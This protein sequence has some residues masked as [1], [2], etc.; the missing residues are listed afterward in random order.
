MMES[1]DPEEIRIGMTRLGTR[2]RSISWLDRL[3]QLTKKEGRSV[4][5][6]IDCRHSENWLHECTLEMVQTIHADPMPI[7]MEGKWCLPGR[8]SSRRH[9][10]DKLHRRTGLHD[11]LPNIL[12][13]PG[14]PECIR[15]AAGSS[16]SFQQNA[17]PISSHAPLTAKACLI[18]PRLFKPR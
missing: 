10:R 16:R 8:T 4:L 2:W 5:F 14:K 1:N 17:S 9:H 7:M 6:V 13:L 3:R 18:C 15:T 11:R 12:R